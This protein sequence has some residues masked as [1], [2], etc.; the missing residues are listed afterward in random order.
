MAYEIP[1]FSYTLIAGE[2]LT[3]SQFCAVDIERGTGAAVLPVEGD[4]VVGI[5]QNKPDD[6]QSCTLVQTGISKV[7]VGA[8]GI[9]AGD[10]V[11]CDDDG[12]IIQASSGDIIVGVAMKTNAS[13]ELGTV[14]LQLGNASGS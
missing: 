9:E 5:L 14:L 2:D 3:G 4:R 11:T 7:K 10:N 6:G 8:T 13:G 1:G 12:T